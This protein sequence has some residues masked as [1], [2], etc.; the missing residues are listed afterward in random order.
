MQMLIAILML[1]IAGCAS[2]PPSDSEN[3]KFVDRYPSKFD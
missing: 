3:S 1:L 2:T